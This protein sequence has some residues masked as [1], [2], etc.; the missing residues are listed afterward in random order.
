MRVGGRGPI[1]ALLLVLG[2]CGF[3]LPSGTYH[4]RQ[5][6]VIRTSCA[7]DPPIPLEWDGD[8]TVRGRTITIEL[9]EAGF[10]YAVAAKSLVGIFQP[11]HRDDPR[12]LSDSTFDDVPS[13]EGVDCLSFTH[14]QIAAT[15][16]EHGVF[17]GVVRVVDS[18]Q[19]E[20][21]R[22]CPF[23]CVQDVEFEARHR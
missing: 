13:L 3:D 11:D 21:N 8:V 2:G 4:F 7:V 1:L 17:R 16:P 5:V 20:A 9:P 23:A 14:I 19:L 6:N 12:F 10:R 22:A 18:R 15:V